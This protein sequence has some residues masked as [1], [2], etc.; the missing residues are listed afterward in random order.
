MPRTTG[1]YVVEEV[2]LRLA[3]NPS[4]LITQAA[5]LAAGNGELKA[6]ADLVIVAVPAGQGP[7]VL[8]AV[9]RAAVD[10]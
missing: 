10:A 3:P 7:D 8:E 9:Y 4:A 6:N 1:A 5:I 2:R